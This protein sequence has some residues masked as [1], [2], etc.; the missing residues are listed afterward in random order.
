MNSKMAL[1]LIVVLGSIHALPNNYLNSFQPSSQLTQSQPSNFFNFDWNNYQQNQNSK[2]SK[3]LFLNQAPIQPVFHQPQ[4]VP[5]QFQPAPFPVPTFP[6]PPVQ[7]LPVLR[8]FQI[9]QPTIATSG[10]VI[11]ENL[12]GGV[13]FN[14]LGKPS[15]HYRDN[16]FCDV[17]HACVHGYQRKTYTC[18]FVGEAQY[19]DQATQKCEFVRNNPT[20]CAS[21]AFYH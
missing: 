4:P 13:P 1:L 21:K 12:L 3:N 9:Q 11:I 2:P 6:H 10:Q 15:G 7:A 5:V 14:C 17:F 19:F 20:G 18:P 16:N 8:P